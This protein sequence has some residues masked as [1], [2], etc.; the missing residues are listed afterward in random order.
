MQIDREILLLNWYV[1]FS[2]SCH[3]NGIVLGR[4][5]GNTHSHIHS[6]THTAFSWIFLRF[7]DR[8]LNVYFSV[9]F[10]EF[11]F[12]VMYWKGFIFFL[13]LHGHEGK[14]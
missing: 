12:F 4:E 2:L 9:F 8:D 1:L 13:E 11:L 3:L 5:E 14:L 7:F 10:G 6:H